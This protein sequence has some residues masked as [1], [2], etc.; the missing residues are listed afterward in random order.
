MDSLTDPERKPALV[1]QVRAEIE[2]ERDRKDEASVVARVTPRP[3]A[4]PRRDV[5]VP[6][7]PFWGARRVQADLQTVWQYLDRNTLF[8]HHWG[9]HKA[10]G[11][12]YERIIREVFEP[13][14]ASLSADAL[15]EGWLEPLI[16]SGYFPC[17]ASGEQL[18]VF[19]PE[20]HSREV[21]RLDFPRQSDGERLCLADYF[22][23]LDS[24]QR[25]VV[26]PE[27][28]DPQADQHA[29]A[30]QLGER[31]CQRVGLIHLRL[32]VGTKDQHPGLI[33][34]TRDVTQE[35]QRRGVRPVKV[36]EQ[37]YPDYVHEIH[38]EATPA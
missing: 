12:E 22:R 16:V 31:L 26:V 1:E 8:R 6:K 23:P 3:G 25:D 38:R 29:R 14:L 33:A 2:A 11:E 30:A 7:P 15:R 17:N 37:Q 34:G 13:E 18:I 27:P 36:I 35:Q 20:N 28:S 32:A 19:D 21:A 24:N 9:G 4:G 10:K 5:V